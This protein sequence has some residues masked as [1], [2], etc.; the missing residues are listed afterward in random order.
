MTNEEWIQRGHPPRTTLIFGR[1]ERCIDQ[2]N[3]CKVGIRRGLL[4]S[5]G[6]RITHRGR[7]REKDRER[8]Q[9]GHHR[10]LF[11]LVTKRVSHR[12]IPKKEESHTMGS[13]RGSPH[14]RIEKRKPTQKDGKEDGEK[15]LEKRIKKKKH[16]RI[17]P[18]F[19]A[20]F[21]SSLSVSSMESFFGHLKRRPCM[22]TLKMCKHAME[23]PHSLITRYFQGIQ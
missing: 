13:R 9:S 10:G 2:T 21:P 20:S 16:R 11:C 5:A 19:M 14:K 18:P 23:V 17:N 12:L 3:G 22:P 15:R 4:C 8:L 1:Q 7:S 6:K